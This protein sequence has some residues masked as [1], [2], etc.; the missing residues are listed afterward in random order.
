[1]ATTKIRVVAKRALRLVPGID[2]L[3]AQRDAALAR[4]AELEADLAEL[5]SPKRALSAALREGARDHASLTEHFDNRGLFI[6]GHAR[7][8]TSI[9]LGAL[10][11]SPDAYI[12]G[13][14]N[15]HVSASRSGFTGWYNA[16]QR[17]FGNPEFKSTY[18]PPLAGSE[19]TGFDVLESLSRRYRYVG[20]KIAFRSPAFGYDF[21]GFIPFYAQCFLRSTYVCT[22]RHPVD[23]IHSCLKMFEHGTRDDEVVKAYVDSYLRTVYLQLRVLFL[24]DRTYFLVHERISPATFD[25]LGR[26]LGLDFGDARGLYDFQF[27]APGRLRDRT[28]SEHEGVGR[29]I[30]LYEELCDLLSG[31]TLRPK[32]LWPCWELTYKLKRELES[33]PQ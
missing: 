27:T 18:C 19:A 3:F 14:A 21:D 1:M 5:R 15:L 28:L 33:G 25:I 26:E 30:Q 16:M 11:T 17:Q 20:D 22:I 31:E 13:E 7:S 23:V 32:R 4:V 24:F 29:L 2:R 12:L 6:V 10:N 8:G 9:L